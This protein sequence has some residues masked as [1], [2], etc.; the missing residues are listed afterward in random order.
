MT[1]EQAVL[2]VSGLPQDGFDTRE[3][4]WWG[5]LLLLL[6]ETTTFAIAVAAFFY[7]NQNFNVWPPPRAEANSLLDPLPS[8]GN[9]TANLIVLVVSALV[10]LWVD[11]AARKADKRAVKIGLPICLALNFGSIVIRAFEFMSIK[12]RWNSNAYGSVVWMILILHLLHL[13]VETA[14]ALILTVYTY[15]RSLDP[16]HRMDITVLAVYW[17]WVTIIWIPLYAIVY[18]GP[19]FR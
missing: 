13:I 10:M 8:L 3:P 2:D 14:E 19:R 18:L 1:E 9:P 12:I 16:K 11:R 6:I 7:V 5:N 17:Y 4:M 15:N